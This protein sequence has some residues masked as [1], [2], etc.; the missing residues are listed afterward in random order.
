MEWDKDGYTI[1][2]DPSRID[3]EQAYRL[4]KDMYWTAGRTPETVKKSMDNS[5][6]FGLYHGGSL[7]GMARVVTD[8]AIFSWIC[9]V[10]VK[11]EHQGRGLGKWL[12]ECICDHPEVKETELVL[13]TMDAQKLYE[14]YG[15]KISG[16]DICWMR[17]VP[18]WMESA[19]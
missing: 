15:F 8:R 18:A 1:S 10:V 11:K 4:L 7:V 13:R 17:K 6:C 19:F 12:L 9:D 14:P 2:A 5:I 3:H 16:G